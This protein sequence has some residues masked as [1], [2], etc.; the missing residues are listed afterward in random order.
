[1]A[2]SLDGATDSAKKLQ[3]ITS[4]MDELNVISPPSDTGGGG[5]GGGLGATGGMTP[6]LSGYDNMLSTVEDVSQAIADKM[7]P[8]LKIAVGLALALGGAFLGWKILS[9]FTGLGKTL[10]LIKGVG[11][12]SAVAGATGVAK[13]GGI[14][15]KVFGVGGI[16]AGG[17]LMFLS[18]KDMMADTTIKIK[19]QIKYLGGLALLVGGV[20]LLFGP[21]TA[22]V[23]LLVGSLALLV[24]AIS[25]TSF[26]N[27][28]KEVELFGEG[29]SKATK[30]KLEPFMKTIE[31]LD[32]AL[33]TLELTKGVI[34]QETADTI[35][36]TANKIK[37][38]ILEELDADR[39]NDLAQLESIKGTMNDEE[40]AELL[41]K[42]NT[43]Y[44]NQVATV[45]ENTDRINEITKQHLKDGTKLTV[46]EYDELNRLRDANEKIAMDSMTESL[47]ELQII[48]S[49]MH[50]NE[51]AD[52]V[53]HVSKML[54]QSA[55]QRDET[56]A[57]AELTYEESKI[58][59]NKMYQLGTIDKNQRDAMILV[60]QNQRDETV[61][62]ATNTY[63]GIYNSAVREMPKI[64]DYLDKAT[65]EQL[66]TFDR[67]FK[68]VIAGYDSLIKK[69]K[70]WAGYSDVEPKTRGSATGNAGY[71]SHSRTGYNTTLDVSASGG[72][73]PSGTAVGTKV[74]TQGGTYQVVEPNS[75]MANEN[76]ETGVW[77]KKLYANG[78][79]PSMGEMF[80][81][82]ESGAEMIG[83]VNGRSA[84]VNNDQIVQAVSQGVAKAVASVMGNQ[85]QQP[86]VL[87]LDGEVIYKNQQ[88]IKSNRGSDFGMGV[89]AK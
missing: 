11:T 37:E 81:A 60:A 53:K 12:A 51:L 45:T 8:A 31:N 52:T 79:F 74:E 78:G 50:K 6:D 9:V 36:G 73:V 4:G 35:I 17:T 47:A 30:E 2:E 62:A 20:F 15:T 29:V 71:S 40:Y 57:D 27:P 3:K 41:S 55:K 19:D 18:F 49:N 46:A 23:V 54:V 7:S 63:L 67:F 64:R 32:V 48:K 58:N 69:V 10:G 33:D 42:T 44:D 59:I 77:S 68:K 85:S 5:S 14:L 43:Y 38:G 22:A 21:L 66:T 24:S 65:G 88:K 87:N 89:F 76:K 1:V 86:V 16:I 82:N 80:V 34:T 61:S 56:I 72:S 25:K 83:N 26:W 28:L 13:F 75:Y 39:N 70:E 84:V